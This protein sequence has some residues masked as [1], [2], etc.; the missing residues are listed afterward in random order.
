VALLVF[1]LSQKDLPENLAENLFEHPLCK[2]LQN[3]HFLWGG[4]KIPKIGLKS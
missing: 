2:T 3:G 4:V 1:P